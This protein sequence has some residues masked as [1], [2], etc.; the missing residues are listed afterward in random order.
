[1]R[2][3]ESPSYLALLLAILPALSP[4][5]PLAAF[6]VDQLE[7]RRREIDTQLQRIATYSLGHGL[8]AIGY[9]SLPHD[10]PHE[11][12]WIEIDLGKPVSLDEIVLVPTIRRDAMQGFQADGFPA[13]LRVVVGV[14]P[15]RVGKTLVDYDPPSHLLPR[16][17]PLVIPGGGTLA[18]WIRIEARVLS[19]RAFDGRPV[20][21]LAEVL[22]F[23]GTENVALRR[24]VK[25][26]AEETLVRGPGWSPA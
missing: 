20:F 14:G 11:T 3:L 5:A 1:M 25:I 10:S 16:I 6:S 18:S 17:A 23:R 4:A 2:R 8:G 19:P 24:P 21:Q 22:A 7:Q 15:D 13:S 26:P 9:R 12:E